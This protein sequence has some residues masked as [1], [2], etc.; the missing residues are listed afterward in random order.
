M[1]LRTVC[2]HLHDICSPQLYIY[3]TCREIHRDLWDAP[4][5]SGRNRR[6][7]GN[8]TLGQSHALQEQRGQL[9]PHHGWARPLEGL[10]LATRI[11]SQGQAETLL[12][13]QHKPRQ[14]A[15]EASRNHLHMINLC[16]RA[17]LSSLSGS[18]AYIFDVGSKFHPT[19][20]QLAA[21][22]IA[23]SEP[24]NLSSEESATF[25]THC[26]SL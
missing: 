14:S 17:Y 22:A 9:H 25:W 5:L 18:S 6:R 24:A 11:H 20:A 3:Y 2:I 21:K 19:L 10:W 16:T 7:W 15:A 23:R 4:N 1:P 8:V 12:S 13:K 26:R